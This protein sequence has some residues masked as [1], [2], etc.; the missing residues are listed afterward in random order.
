MALDTAFWRKWHRWISFP[1]VV[2]L[3][4]AS[5]TGVI[6]A[7]TEFFGE[8]EALREATRN[9]ESPI[10]TSSPANAWSEPLAAVMT[11]AAT[12]NAGAPIDKIQMQFKG[13]EPTVTLFLGKRGGGEDRQLVYSLKTQ[14]L[15]REESYADKP[16]IHRL[17]SGEAFG[18]GGLVM[19]MAWGAALT[20]LTVSGFIIYLRMR[21]TGATGLAKIF[22]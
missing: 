2:F 11:A 6:V 21:R 7:A 8:E 1:A 4:F 22:W 20:W 10:A 14:T 9:I 15:V 18:D 19:A 16:F 12:S 17:H 3:L 5:I 13:D